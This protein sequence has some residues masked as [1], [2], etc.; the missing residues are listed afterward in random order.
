MSNS[1]KMKVGF[2]GLG[3]MGRGMARRI[4]DAGHDLVVFDVVRE[5]T[6]EFAAAG[7]RV[8]PS[9]TDRLLGSRRRR[10]DAG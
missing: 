1:N 2:V 7:A 8:A 9:V 5:Q 6:A 3:R 10:Y 4:L